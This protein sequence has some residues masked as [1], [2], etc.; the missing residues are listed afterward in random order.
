METDS[1]TQLEADKKLRS[2]CP[3]LFHG[4][5]GRSHKA[6]RVI[7]NNN[8]GPLCVEYDV[9]SNPTFIT[10]AS[11]RYLEGLNEEHLDPYCKVPIENIPNCEYR[12]EKCD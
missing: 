4:H 8:N 11:C 9:G 5:I 12:N 1:N 3:N 10:W 2:Y 7:D 6:L